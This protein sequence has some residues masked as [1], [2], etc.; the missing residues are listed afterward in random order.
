V[1]DEN[2]NIINMKRVDFNFK[3]HLSYSTLK[4]FPQYSTTVPVM[5]EIIKYTMHVYNRYYLSVR[6]NYFTKQ[7][8][9]NLLL[10]VFVLAIASFLI[11]GTMEKSYGHAFLTSSNPVASQSLASP[12]GNIEAFFSEPVDIKYSQ[13]K[14]LDPNGKEVDNKDIHHIDG[15]QSSLSVT[16][17]PLGDGVY[18]VSTNVLSQVDG[19]VT[20]SAF[21]F[22]VGQAAI[23]SNLSSTNSESSIIYVPEAIARFPTLVGQVMIVGGAFSV[24]WL[25]RPFS[26]IQWLSD[27]LLETRKNI[28]KRL[29]SLFL[30]G[31]IILVLSDFAIVVF[32]ASAISATLFDV[33][34]TRFGMVLVARIFLSLTLLGVSL[35]EFRRFRK[36]KT[37]LSKGEMTGIISLGITLLLTTSLIGHGAANNQF[38]SIAID[39]VH[40]LTASIWIGGVIYLAFVLIP[41]LKGEHS[42][43]EYTKIAF[44]TLLIPRFSTSVIVVLGFIV[45]TGPFLLYIL[46]NRFDLLISSLYG[47]TIIVKLTLATIMLALGAY[48]QLIIYRDSMKYTS[49]PM[50]VAEGHTGSK[51]SPDFDPPEGKRQKKSTGKSRDIVSRFSRS[52]KIESIVGIILLA[53][54]AF[55]VNTGLPQSEFQSQIR[56]QDSPS[57]VT[58]PVT[59]VESFKATGFIDNNTRVILSITPFV[60]GSNNFSISFVDSKSNHIDM[61]LAEM[62]YTEIEK[63]IGPIDVELQQ[64]SKGVFFVKAAFGI[65]GVWYIQIEGVPNK[66]NVPRIV[67]T[68]ENIIVKP[69][70]DQLQFTANR[71]EIPGNRSQPLYPIYDSNRNAIWVGDT[72]IDSGRILEFRLDSNKY[73]EH[74]IDG[75]SIITVAAQDSNGKIWYVDP[76]TKHLGSY[77]PSTISNKL[78]L[79]PNR[80]IPSAIAIDIANKVWITSP[81]TNEILRFDPSKGNFTSKFHLQ[82]KDASPIAIAIDSVSGIIWV[83]DEKGKLVRIDPSKNYTLTEFVPRG[84]NETLRSPTALLVD[85]VSGSIYISQHEGNRV[86]KFN[87]LTHAFNHYGPLD[88]NGL[89]FGMTLDKYRNLWVAEHTVNKI[90]VIDQQTGIVREVTLQGQSPF[91]QWLTSD[92]EGNVWFAEQKANA[93][94]VIKSTVESG[95]PQLGSVESGKGIAEKTLFE[96]LP[97]SQIVAPSVTIALIMVAF[98]YV[99]SVIDFKTSLIKLN[100]GRKEN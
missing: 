50:T 21:V 15:D 84:I 74:K 100:K 19:H 79:L 31:S 64:V 59:G 86:S 26:K 20:K 52:T 33:L 11:C 37:V 69:K 5:R 36:S 63:S 62:K 3:Y 41:K 45:I 12:P 14:V 89:P 24:L 93:L 99:K 29:V 70:V 38:S 53:S 39:F 22:A 7:R 91:V 8:N 85:Q 46:E 56:Q 10:T 75:I 58:S 23:P 25:W 61:K 57:S 66:S 92:S 78:Y 42:L 65:P 6:V 94:G 16:L 73:I 95:L 77:D 35:F 82:N 9:R 55:L 4:S 47:K 49:V 17:L 2:R 13:V 88:P 32:Q 30:L 81:T 40:N 71:F 48:N 72:T 34:T 28:D 76:L 60:V 96:G 44:L 54:V 1:N 43:N 98:M 51:T 87:P 27:I 83:A 80:V 97:Y 90:A 67:A 68:F 18:T